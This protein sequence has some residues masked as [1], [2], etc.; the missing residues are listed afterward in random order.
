M[1]FVIFHWNIYFA[2]YHFIGL[3]IFS[4]SLSGMV[5]YFLVPNPIRKV[6][7]DKWL[8]MGYAPSYE[9]KKDNINKKNGNFR[10]KIQISIFVGFTIIPLLMILNN[11]SMTNFSEEKYFIKNVEAKVYKGKYKYHV[12]NVYN[13]NRKIKFNLG[14]NQVVNISDLPNTDRLDSTIFKNSKGGYYP[15]PV[16][17]RQNNILLSANFITVKSRKS[18]LGFVEVEGSK[19]NFQP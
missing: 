8:E 5:I 10:E 9:D 4:S 1:F 12:F 18:I 13:D 11:V 6:I 14:F 3:L 19:C 7:W 16:L 17:Q 15:E 2:F